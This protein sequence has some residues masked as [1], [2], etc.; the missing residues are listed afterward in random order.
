MAWESPELLETLEIQKY[1]E[2]PRY[3]FLQGTSEM[4]PRAGGPRI[5]NTEALSA[6]ELVEV[7]A[8]SLFYSIKFDNNRNERPNAAAS[9]L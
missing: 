2:S 3:L 9:G 1:Q 7:D 6:A 5:H 4:Y 8:K